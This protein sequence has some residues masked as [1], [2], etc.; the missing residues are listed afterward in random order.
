M[1]DL[2]I[3]DV[4]KGLLTIMRKTGAAILLIHHEPRNSQHLFGS[5]FCDAM[6]DAQIHVERD[7]DIVAVKVELLKNGEL[8]KRPFVYRI[9]EQVLSGDDHSDGNADRD[10]DRAPSAN[11][12]RY[13]AMLAATAGQ[14]HPRDRGATACRA[15]AAGRHSG[16]EA[17]AMA[18]RLKAMAKAGE[19][20]RRAGM[21]QRRLA[22]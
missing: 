12:N 22:H 20:T 11:G 8:P 14:V 1:Q 21:M 6:L 4:G 13:S 18:T 10:E 3:M 15:F 7:A 16:G 9:E 19:I 5:R 17:A 2:A